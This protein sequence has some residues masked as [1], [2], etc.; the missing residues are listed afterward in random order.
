MP[1]HNLRQLVQLINWLDWL[2]HWLDRRVI[3]KKSEHLPHGLRLIQLGIENH[4][5]LDFCSGK[6]NYLSQTPW[7]LGNIL[8]F[9]RLNNE[10]LNQNESTDWSMAGVKPIR[11]PK[12]NASSISSSGI[13]INRQRTD[14]QHS[15][16]HLSNFEARDPK[17]G[18]S[19]DQCPGE[20]C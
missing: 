8:K 13:V 3:N 19:S 7:A 4:W 2:N 5:F 9:Y 14:L 17:W 10:S 6:T 11:C 20:V 18:Q 15:R 1:T 12:L 16:Q